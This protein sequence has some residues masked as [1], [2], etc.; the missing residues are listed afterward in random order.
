MTITPV[1][2]LFQTDTHVTI[3][4]RVPHIRVSRE[5]LQIELSDDDA[6]LHFASLPIYTLRLNFTL[7]QFQPYDHEYD[8]DGDDNDGGFGMIHDL[9]DANILCNDST[10]QADSRQNNTPNPSHLSKVSFH[11]LLQDGTVRIELAK[12]IAGVHW[13]DLDL[14]GKFLVSPSTVRDRNGA[15]QVARPATTSH[16]LHQVLSDDNEANENAGGRD[17]EGSGDDVSQQLQPSSS[18]TAPVLDEVE[19]GLYG[20]GHMFW[21]VFSDFNRDGL[22]KEMLEG[23]WIRDIQ[24]GPLTCATLQL[25]QNRLD[26]CRRRS[27]DCNLAGGCRGSCGRRRA[28]LHVRIGDEL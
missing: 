27:V 11:P 12:R 9:D 2:A 13:P 14:I 21:G 17:D 26:F 8:H 25:L 20:F 15:S 7:H 4:I 19:R 10:V 23:P 16:W 3:E 1:F 18:I 5:S 22:A 6:V 28:L 24:W